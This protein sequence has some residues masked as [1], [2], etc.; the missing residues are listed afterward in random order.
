VLR[1][2]LKGKR[3]LL[4]IIILL[5]IW[6]FLLTFFKP[7]LLLLK[8]R[9][10]GGD[11]ASHYYTA[12]YLRDVLL[13]QGKIMGWLRANYA[14]F[15]L[16]YHYFPLTFLLMAL[17]SYVIPLEISFKLVTVLGTFLLPLC[18]YIMFR[19][20]EYEDPVPILG[21]IFSLAFLFNERNSMWGG[22]IPSTLAG[23]FSFSFSLAVFVVLIGTLYRGMSENK[24]VIFNAALFFLMGFSHGYTLVFLAFLSFFFLFSRNI[25]RNIWYMFRVYA[26]GSMFLAFWFLPFVANLPYVVPFHMIWHFHSVWEIFPPILIPFFALSVLAILFNRRDQRTYYFGFALGIGVV[27]YFL[28][29]RL[30]LVDIRFLTFLQFLLA[31]FGATALQDISKNI[32]LPQLIPVIAL[33]AMLLWVNINTGYIKSWI[34]WNYSGFEQK[35]TWPQVKKLFDYLRK[36][37]D[38]GRAVYENSVKYEALGTQRIFESLRMF[39]GRDTLEGLYMQ[40]S[41]TGPYAFYIQSEISKDVSA[42]FWSYPVS[43]FNLKNG[44][45]HLNMFNV[46]QFI[47]RS[48]KV[49]NAIRGMPE[50]QFEKR[51]GELDVYRVANTDRHY[52]V[53]AR[54]APVRFTKKDWKMSFYNWFKVPR[55]QEV[56]VVYAPG[57][58]EGSRFK[59]QTSDAA[60]APKVP[61]PV[62]WHR[63]T[64]KVGNETIEFE[65]NLIGHP[66]IIRVSY[67][68]NWRVEGAK[69]VYL[70]TPTFMLVYPEQ[71]KVKLTF[72]KS[73]YNYLGETISALALLGV[74]AGIFLKKRRPA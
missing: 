54:Y 35:D 52:V 45:Q 11:T 38:G 63:I 7:S 39:A 29:P 62:P 33:L 5:F 20:M 58:G 40:S 27:F 70:V 17:L 28:G 55:L 34:A 14:G 19:V 65:T 16:F 4:D 66:H 37:D 47:V 43:P 68:P 41:I 30:G 25:V 8:T 48:D 46:T 32:R 69:R 3:F 13:P 1:Q 26:L 18:V 12:Q 2:L 51:F 57:E 42:P 59:H 50:Y 44:A 10:A 56:P 23:E 9:T 72:A 6:A 53:P 64:E 74:I 15:P 36:T 24:Y 49:R 73:K 67:H 31:I 61:L 71:N 22:N 21:G 60:Q